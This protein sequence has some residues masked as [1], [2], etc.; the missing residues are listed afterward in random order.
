MAS[1]F[2]IKKWSS[3]RHQ[4]NNDEFVE[5]LLKNCSN[6]FNVDE[7]GHFLLHYILRYT[8]KEMSLFAL[9]ILHLNI[10]GMNIHGVYPIHVACRFSSF[11]V[12]V[13][14][15]RLGANVNVVSH[16]GWSTLHFVCSRNTGIYRRESYMAISLML[17]MVNV[18]FRSLRDKNGFAPIHL[19]CMH[20][21]STNILILAIKNF[22][23]TI[24]DN[25][26]NG[27]IDYIYKYGNFDQ[28]QIIAEMGL[29]FE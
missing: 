11:E 27:P 29:E 13:K 14:C 25:Y 5:N 6:K 4:L 8:S 9:D 7:C 17:K 24:R 10:N 15:I 23:I 16:L 3:I 18:N 22:D 1:T 19:L 26:G 21:K 20:N 28:W 2:T 12:V